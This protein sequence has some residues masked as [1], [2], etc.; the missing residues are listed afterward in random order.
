MH[1]SKLFLCCDKLDLL[2]KLE[3]LDLVGLIISRAIKILRRFSMSE[4]LSGF[5]RIFTQVCNLT[6]GGIFLRRCQEV[7]IAWRNPK[8][9]IVVRDVLNG[10][11]QCHAKF[12]P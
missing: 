3:A 2:E 9:G 6:L 1:T 12:N 10:V 11:R 7:R 4:I 5:G 8:S